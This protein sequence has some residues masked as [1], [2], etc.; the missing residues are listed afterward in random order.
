MAGTMGK[1][2]GG[3][4]GE[5]C[6]GFPCHALPCLWEIAKLQSGVAFLR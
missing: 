1:R 3:V 5:L 2:V 6:G 4:K